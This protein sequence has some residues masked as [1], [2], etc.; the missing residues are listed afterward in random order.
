MI[1]HRTMTRDDAALVLDWAANEGWNPGL[2]DAAVFCRTDPD[3]FFLA[4]DGNTPVAAISV[5]NHSDRFAFLGLY[6]CHP[7]HRGRGIGFD[8]WRHAIRHAG[9][10]TIGLDG[11]PEQQSNYER[12][13]FVRSGATTRYSGQIEPLADPAVRP[14]E[15][16]DIPALIELEASASGWRK[17]TYLS[18]WF[19][20]T[21][22]RKTYVSDGAAGPEGV[23]TIRRCRTGCKIGPLIA[24]TAET[25]LRLARHAVARVAAES[26]MID[27][28]A[29]SAGLD[30]LC[31]HLNLAPGF[32]TA[33][34]YRGPSR[35]ARH[36]SYAVASLELG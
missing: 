18:G 34:M 31:R 21:D 27:V 16:S 3:G 4:V 23:V 17:D 7:S 12:S 36:E 14:V 26:V 11:V 1:R 30:A 19:T 32:S 25:S 2:D 24:T 9:T 10:R 35:E 33:R 6:L 8:L 29:S 20:D 13:G 22:T 15:V 5:V 28:P